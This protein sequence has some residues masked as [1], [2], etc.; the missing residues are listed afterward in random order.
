[1]FTN[2]NNILPHFLIITATALNI[3]IAA[4]WIH[5]TGCASASHQQKVESTQNLPTPGNLQPPVISDNLS[6][7]SDIQAQ[8]MQDTNI[9]YTFEILVSDENGQAK[10]IM[11]LKPAKR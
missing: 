2:K 8:N 3:L 5:T 7:F 6:Y 4:A 1:M 11:K 10:K 9:L